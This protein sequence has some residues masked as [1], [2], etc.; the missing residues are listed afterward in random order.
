MADDVQFEEDGTMWQVYSTR[1]EDGIGVTLLYYDVERVAARVADSNEELE[2]PEDLL[3]DD[4]DVERSSPTEV[5]KWIDD[6]NA[7]RS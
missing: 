3:S 2:D 6:W 5:R 7:G 1:W 4:S